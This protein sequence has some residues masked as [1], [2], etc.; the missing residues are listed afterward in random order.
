MDGGIL[1]EEAKNYVSNFL[2]V[3]RV[4]PADE[5]NEGNSDDAASDPDVELVAADVAE[6]FGKS[7]TGAEGVRETASAQA[8]REKTFASLCAEV[9]ATW[10]SA[11]EA[12]ETSGFGGQGFAIM[13]GDFKRATA[14]ARASRVSV[15]ARLTSAEGAVG[16]AATALAAEQ[17]VQAGVHA[18]LA[19][20]GACT[21]QRRAICF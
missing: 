5:G 20:G 21:V 18:G 17:D 10:G 16:V 1:C 4:R 13:T 6:I 11:S 14:D 12:C 3:H 15:S 8:L 9:E 2:S 7:A 19:Q